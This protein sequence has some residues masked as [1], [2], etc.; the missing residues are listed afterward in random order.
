MFGTRR[1]SRQKVKIYAR[2]YRADTT[3][4]R[5]PR[6]L[7]RQKNP[8]YRCESRPAQGDHFTGIG[9][10]EF[11]GWRRTYGMIQISATEGT[12]RSARKA[13]TFAQARSAAVQ[14]TGGTRRLQLLW[15]HSTRNLEPPSRDQSRELSRTRMPPSRIEADRQTLKFARRRPRPSVLQR[16]GVSSRTC[17]TTLGEHFASTSSPRYLPSGRPRPFRAPWHRPHSRC[18]A[19]GCKLVVKP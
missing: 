3:L 16:T 4:H 10:S 9:R 8:R 13:A 14:L 17:F 11:E 19:P 5:E 6:S 1:E 12:S 2:A 7:G 15:S 18:H